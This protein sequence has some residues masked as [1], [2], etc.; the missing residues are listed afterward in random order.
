MHLLATCVTINL[1]EIY[2]KKMNYHEVDK[3]NIIQRKI[4]IDRKH[5]KH[6]TKYI[7]H[8]QIH[9]FILD[10]NRHVRIIKFDQ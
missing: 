6:N 10:I 8:K 9:S 5:D 2:G 4:K 1:A 3:K 7:Y